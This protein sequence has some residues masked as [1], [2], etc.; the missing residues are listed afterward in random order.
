MHFRIYVND[1][2]VVM[3]EDQSTN[4]TN[5]DD[6]LLKRKTTKP[7]YHTKRMLTSGTRISI[8]MHEHGEYTFIVRIPKREGEYERAYRKNLA[9]YLARLR[10]LQGQESGGNDRTILPRPGDHVSDSA[11]C[12]HYH[13]LC[14]EPPLA[15]C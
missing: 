12:M 14:V 1:F 2:G 4:G 9:Q 5:V 11:R 7:G 10:E 6:Q 3:I 15:S 8:P 13:W